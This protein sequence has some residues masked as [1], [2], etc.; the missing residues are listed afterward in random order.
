MITKVEGVPKEDRQVFKA[1]VLQ[2]SPKF[3]V[4]FIADNAN[5]FYDGDYTITDETLEEKG[6]AKKAL[7]QFIAEFRQYQFNR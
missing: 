2:S 6:K 3:R 7:Q 4:L 1:G 5:I